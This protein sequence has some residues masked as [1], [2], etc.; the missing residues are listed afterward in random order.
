VGVWR[1]YHPDGTLKAEKDFGPVPDAPSGSG[2][3]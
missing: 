3:A 2:G 1:S